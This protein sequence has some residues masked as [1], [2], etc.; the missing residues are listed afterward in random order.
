MSLDQALATLATWVGRSG[1]EKDAARRLE[2]AAILLPN[3]PVAQ[4]A[5][6]L[7][8]KGAEQQGK[9]P[10]STCALVALRFLAHV[11]C[12]CLEHQRPYLPRMG[13]A[14]ADVETVAR[15]HGAWLTSA[16]DLATYP[17]PGDILGMRVSNPHISVV[18][19][20]RAEDGAILSIDGGQGDNTWTKPRA[21]T[22]IAPE[23]AAA[24][25]V[26]L[27]DGVSVSAGKHSV[28]YARVDTS[29]IVKT[30]ELCR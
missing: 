13:R 24:Y 15:R 26:D 28:L 16:A 17:K 3:D 11:G 12:R 8:S 10:T 5:H 21:R 30:L 1:R 2:W 19:D 9:I 6:Y 4:A 20:S 18:V 25:L 23:S 27:D 29:Q 7:E 14:I 22:L